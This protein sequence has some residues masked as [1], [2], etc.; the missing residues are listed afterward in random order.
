[1]SNCN[2]MCAMFCNCFVFF[3]HFRDQACCRSLKRSVKLNINCLVLKLFTFILL[4]N[5]RW[6]CTKYDG[7]NELITLSVCKY[8]IILQYVYVY[9]SRSINCALCIRI[10][11]IQWHL[12]KIQV[13]YY[14]WFYFLPTIEHCSLFC[15]LPFF[16]SLSL[17]FSLFSLSVSCD[18][19]ILSIS[20]STST[21]L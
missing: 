11:M 8:A 18:F 15:I 12:S 17:S 5:V 7:I 1:M 20:I 4:Q 21:G 13:F 9:D 14:P 3:F 6:A 2:W 19:P 10:L 16:L